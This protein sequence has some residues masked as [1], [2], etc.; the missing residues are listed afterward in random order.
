MYIVDLVRYC[1]VNIIRVKYFLSVTTINI[2]IKTM[3]H[4]RHVWRSVKVATSDLNVTGLR[5]PVATIL[6]VLL[7]NSLKY[8]PKSPTFVAIDLFM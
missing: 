6:Y 5:P 8:K 2:T 7:V 4:R 3:H 1:R